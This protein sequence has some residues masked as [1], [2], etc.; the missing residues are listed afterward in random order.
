M[1]SGNKYFAKNIR[2]YSCDLRSL[3]KPR[4]K[5]YSVPKKA[6][7]PMQLNMV[8]SGQLENYRMF[9]VDKS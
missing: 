8:S 3:R 2:R 4:G 7:L 9:N 6:G 1:F 5:G